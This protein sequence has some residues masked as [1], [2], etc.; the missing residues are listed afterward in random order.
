[1]NY[2]ISLFYFIL[3]YI[4]RC[5]CVLQVAE[6]LMTIAYE[7]GVNLFDT[8]EVYAAGKWVWPLTHLSLL[9][10]RD[11]TARLLMCLSYVTLCFRLQF[12]AAVHKKCINFLFN[13]REFSVGSKYCSV[14]TVS[15]EH[16]WLVNQ[17][18]FCNDSHVHR[19]RVLY[20]LTVV[21][22]VR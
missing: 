13:T 20:V 22:S 10:T 11:Y 9:Y 17:G 4:I 15:G 8:A 14:L 7:N 1:M 3:F 2:S 21:L 5:V 18:D 19:G 6:Q 12:A 16:R